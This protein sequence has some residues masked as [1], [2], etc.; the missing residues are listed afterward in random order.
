MKQRY[1]FRLARVLRV[2]EV[3][4]QAARASLGEAQARLRDAERERDDRRATLAEARG[5]VVRRLAA[6]SV[7]P[8][9]VLSEQRAVDG[10]LARLAAAREVVLTRLAQADALQAA[11]RERER[12]LR[13]L[14]E[15][16][17]RGLHRHRLDLARRENAKLD[18]VASSRDARR[19]LAAERSARKEETAS[20]PSRAPV[21]QGGAPST[22]Y[23]QR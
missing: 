8:A 21:D 2:R 22:P 17:E 20:S 5:D 15:L 10:L 23:L 3:A 12:D 13:A 7:E 18:E 19:R 14:T 9:L 4:E 6:G 1:D 16:R 11:W